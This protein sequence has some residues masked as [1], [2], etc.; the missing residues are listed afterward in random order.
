MSRC[1]EVRDETLQLLAKH[2]SNTLE[3]LYIKG[4]VNVSDV[5]VMAICRGCQK[6]KVL[7]VS[8]TAITDDSGVA[9]GEHLSNLRALYT[10]DNFRL[11]NRSIDSITANCTKL[12]Q[13][14]LWGC[15]KLHHLNF[16]VTFGGGPGENGN[17]SSI[18]TASR[19]KETRKGN[20]KDAGN[21]RGNQHILPAGSNNTGKLVSL[22]LWGC[23]K[24]GDDIAVALGNMRNLRSLIVSEC[25]RLT[26]QFAVSKTLLPCPG[27]RGGCHCSLSHHISSGLDRLALHKVYHNCSIFICGIVCG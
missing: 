19:S 12:N 24:L 23:V 26:D 9:I 3:V 1:T 10:R 22:N 6:L 17:S 16:G 21:A 2:N 7:D 14:T 11:T 15:V 4:L 25:H 5:G 27:G 8:Y 13:L 20:E 18:L